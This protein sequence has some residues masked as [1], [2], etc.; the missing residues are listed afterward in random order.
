MSLVGNSPCC[1]RCRLTVV[2]GG[3]VKKRLKRGGLTAPLIGEAE[4][5][6]LPLIPE[7]ELPLVH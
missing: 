3:A 6:A 2:R 4:P 1:Y 7:G 5:V